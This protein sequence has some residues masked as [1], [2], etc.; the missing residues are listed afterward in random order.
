MAHK[1]GTRGVFLYD[2]PTLSKLKSCSFFWEN[3][4][5][6]ESYL[7]E[8]VEKPDLVET[9]HILLKEGVLKICETPAGLK[10]ALTDKI[11][12]G[13]NEELWEYIHRN[14]PK[15]TAEPKLPE[16]AEEIIKE[17]TK[18][19]SQDATLGSLIDKI[20]HDTIEDK[21]MSALRENERFPY[22]SMPPAMKRAAIAEVKKLTDFEYKHYR[23]RNSVARFNFEGRNRYFLTQM[24]VSTALFT[25]MAWLPYYSYKFADY[26]ARDARKYLEGVNAVM[27]FVRRESIDSFSIDEI[28]KIRRSRRWNA[29]MAKLAEL[30]NEVKYGASPA[31]FR[32]EIE[33][34]VICEYQ[35]ALG[36]EEATLKDVGKQLLKGSVFAGVSF[37]PIIGGIVSTIAGIADPIISYAQKEGAQ[38]NLPFFLNDLRKKNI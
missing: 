31:E 7:S 28:L 8:V 25:P 21:W 34:K 1:A 33:Q 29:A 38:R 24:S 5:V 37:V 14:T 36:E 20:V 6:F 18:R 11:Y 9:T 2:E 27:P 16:N 32:E 12:S 13:L 10:S 3:V 17:S 22:V 26:S 19:D 23:Q 35:D 4:V 30:C 15:V